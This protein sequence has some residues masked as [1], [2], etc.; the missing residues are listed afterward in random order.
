MKI[1]FCGGGTG[2]HVTPAIAI[3]DYAQKLNN[4]TQFAFVG[5]LN[6]KE[7]EIIKS[8]SYKLYE[9]EIYG[10]RRAL[11]IKNIKL[12]FVLIKAVKKSREI[13]KEFKPEVVIGTGGYVCLPVLKAA[14]SLGIP[15]AIHESNAYPGLVTRLLSKKCNLVLL[16]TGEAKEYLKRKDNVKIVGNPISSAFSEI[17][18][19]KARL[20]LGIKN[21]EF[22][23]VSFGGSG[24]AEKLNGV[25]VEFIK[26]YS[27][28]EASVKHIHASGEKYYKEII[29][30]NP[31]FKSK[32]HGVEIREYIKNMPTL[33]KASD[34]V[35]ARSG[36]MSV[37]EI[38]ASSAVSILIPSPNVT[39][40]HQYKNAKNLE[41][42]NAAI[43]IKEENLNYET[44]K[45]EVQKLRKNVKRRNEIKKNT[46]DV[47]INN[48]AER[49][50]EEINGI[51]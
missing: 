13:I 41:D 20:E 44:L 6:G 5:R 33:L 18:R 14:Q 30:E 26:K 12:P 47:F 34:L 51:L 1:L 22:L 35:I 42:K 29:K 3:A 48:S 31:E 36:A 19:N 8:K 50:I 46:K 10:L 11:S 49:I 4:E 24:G 39:N 32:Y 37:S 23:I 40:N 15:T 45:E 17:T 2:G 38:L 27:T 43:V 16:N 28:K 7:N 9:I 25:I 21:N